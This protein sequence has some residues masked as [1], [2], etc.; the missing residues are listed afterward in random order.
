M[1]S[2]ERT[3]AAPPRPEAPDRDRARHLRFVAHEMRNPLAAALWSAELLA[4]L[5]PDERGGARGEKLAR[6]SLRA[7]R[8]LR[9]LAEDHLLAERLDAG[10]LPLHPEAVA[11]SDLLPNDLAELG[12][13]RVDLELEA[14]LSVVAD[15]GLAR[16]ALEGVLLAGARGGSG[17]RLR[18][19]RRE[20]EAVFAVS[21]AH[22]SSSDLDD[23]R[24]GGADPRG[25][26]LA[27]G[28]A[29]RAAQAL[30]GSLRVE[31]GD[32]VLRLPAADPVPGPG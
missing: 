2:L 4:S 32:L 26:S 9:R 25:A 7:L 27:L 1:G 22:C 6:M 21:G 23:P 30:G 31:G 14:G 28:A 13:S 3:A 16:R 17:V 12:A 5:A 20:G 24:T 29:R 18:A 10:G 15:P 19:S 11:A 8:R